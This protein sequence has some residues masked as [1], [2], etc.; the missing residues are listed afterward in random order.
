M[1]VRGEGA[2]VVRTTRLSIAPED[3]GAKPS[4]AKRDDTNRPQQIHSR[5]RQVEVGRD[6]WAR[7]RDYRGRPGGTSLP[8]LP[9]QGVK[10]SGD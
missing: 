1:K 6:R 8:A 2:E 5:A 3:Q 9:R 7:R 4:A 10:A